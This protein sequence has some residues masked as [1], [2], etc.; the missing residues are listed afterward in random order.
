MRG[1]TVTWGWNQIWELYWHKD[2]VSRYSITDRTHTQRWNLLPKNKRRSWL[3]RAAAE[4]SSREFMATP[5][6]SREAFLQQQT[7]AR[8]LHIYYMWTVKVLQK[9]R[10]YFSSLSPVFQKRVKPL[11][12][13]H[14]NGSRVPGKHFQYWLQGWTMTSRAIA[15]WLFGLAVIQALGCHCFMSS[16]TAGRAMQSENRQGVCFFF[17]KIKSCNTTEEQMSGYLRRLPFFLFFNSGEHR[18]GEKALHHINKWAAAEKGV[19]FFKICFVF[20]FCV[21][22]L[23]EGEAWKE[24]FVKAKEGGFFFCSSGA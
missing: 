15:G 6:K 5:W 8:V 23:L 14:I 18:R 17:L 22:V 13:R 7:S 12:H 16:F 1:R 9:S 3:S 20:L 24:Y 11:L 19:S 4:A 21:C 2:T 10:T